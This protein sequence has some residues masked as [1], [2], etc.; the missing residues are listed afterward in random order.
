MTPLHNRTT[1][2]FSLVANDTLPD[3]WPAHRRIRDA[4]VAPRAQVG[5]DCT[6]AGGA[7]VGPGVTLGAGNALDRGARVF[8]GVHLPDGA[9][10]F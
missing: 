7:V 3:G 10:A 5:A 2:A 4:I 6:I 9:L 1:V 8:P